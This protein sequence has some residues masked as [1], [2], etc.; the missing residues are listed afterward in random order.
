MNILKNP[1]LYNMSTAKQEISDWDKHFYIRQMLY[2]TLGL[3]PTY[4]SDKSILEVGIG[5]G[6][7]ALYIASLRPQFY[8]L[9]EATEIGSKSCKEL[10]AKHGLLGDSIDIKN[11]LIESY[12][13]G[14]QF[15]AVI[16]ENML[17]GIKDK[18]YILD[19]LNTYVKDRGILI[20]T[21]TDEISA[22]FDLTRRLLANI[23]IQRSHTND[24]EKMI[25]LC[26]SAFESHFKALGSNKRMKDW[27]LDLTGNAFYVNGFSIIDALTFFQK[28]YFF[29][30]SSPR[31]IVD[32]TWYK[33]VAITS[34]LYNE[35]I[36]DNFDKIHHNL[37]HYKSFDHHVWVKQDS[38][39]LRNLCRKFID[40][41]QKG[42]QSYESVS[43]DISDVLHA[44]KKLYINNNGEE[45]VISTIID[46]ETFLSKDDITPDSVAHGFNYYQNAF[47]RETEYLSLVKSH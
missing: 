15:D 14:Q 39:E 34:Q 6:H 24:G 4:F 19:K 8:Q 12:K 21:C 45:I 25:D 42:E 26:T 32:E 11:M 9:I 36:I 2:Q 20:I 27:C 23:L 44:I 18:N 47:G 5:E 29:Y 43:K 41:T 35:K 3:P 1:G 10:F 30:N 33:H 28:E 16:C 13:S 37:I 17:P 22:F 46:F 31:I 7:N 38:K 40:L